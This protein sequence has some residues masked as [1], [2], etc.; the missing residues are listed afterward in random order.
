VRA[1][2]DGDGLLVVDVDVDVHAELLELLELLLLQS[3]ELLHLAAL[4]CELWAGL[5]FGPRPRRNLLR[6]LREP[7]DPVLPEHE[8]ARVSLS[9]AGLLVALGLRRVEPCRLQAFTR[10]SFLLERGLGA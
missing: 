4:P 2:L 5:G 10:R 3:Q 7:H 6:P 1:P 9:L 8:L